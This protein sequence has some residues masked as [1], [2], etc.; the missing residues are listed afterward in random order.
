M[1]FT[2]LGK[3]KILACCFLGD[4]APELYLAAY[5]KTSI[6][7]EEINGSGYERVALKDLLSIEKDG[8]LTNKEDIIFP[9]AKK[10]WGVI[11]A[12]CIID[13][14]GEKFFIEDV[15][16]PTPK[17]SIGKRLRI[18]QGMLSISLE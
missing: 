16:D 18:P 17:I 11:A 2:T 8:T 5:L 9:L 7:L 15:K 4:K 1:P 10:G 3:N 14:K 13:S 12:L 6:G